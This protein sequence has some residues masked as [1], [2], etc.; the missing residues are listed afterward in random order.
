MTWTG[1]LLI[2][3]SSFAGAYLATLTFSVISFLRKRAAFINLIQ[4]M[5]DQMDT[6]I[7]FR[8]IVETNFNPR[9]DNQ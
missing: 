9:E 1:Y 3:V 4:D 8:K 2:G 6:E 5:K 7:S